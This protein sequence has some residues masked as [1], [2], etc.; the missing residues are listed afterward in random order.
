MC[1][2][3]ITV[4]KVT[5]GVFYRES[6]LRPR[7][8]GGHKTQGGRGSVICIVIEVSGC[9]EHIESADYFFFFLKVSQISFL[10]IFIIYMFYFSLLSFLFF[11]LSWIVWFS[12]SRC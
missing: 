5:S 3:V 2:D 10:F 7:Q 1:R 9:S 11:F 12:G 4:R 6:A 8:G